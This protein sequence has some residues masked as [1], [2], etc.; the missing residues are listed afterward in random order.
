MA[1]SDLASWQE[2]VLLGCCPLAFQALELD[3]Q[4]SAPLYSEKALV[5]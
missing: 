1:N 5:F 4:A 2:L 3:G